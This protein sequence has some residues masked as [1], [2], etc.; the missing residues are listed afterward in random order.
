M[1]KSVVE[2]S[3][4]PKNILL[5]NL[6][7]VCLM[8]YVDEIRESDFPDFMPREV[9]ERDQ[10]LIA[11]GVRH[12]TISGYIDSDEYTMGRMYAMLRYTPQY[13]CGETCSMVIPF[14]MRHVSGRAMCGYA[15]HPWIIETLEWLQSEEAA[16]HRSRLEGLLLGYHP[17]AIE[18]DGNAFLG[19]RFRVNE[20]DR[21]NSNQQPIPR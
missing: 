4:F 6:G 9:L 1:A 11:H 19:R 14:V 10:F 7:P 12:L 21:S 3:E 2:N 13:G 8:E 15:S 5:G 17:D 20:I 16:P 18:A